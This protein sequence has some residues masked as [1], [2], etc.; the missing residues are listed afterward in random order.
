[1]KFLLVCT[2]ILGL[3]F[4]MAS[5]LP[6]LNDN[7]APLVGDGHHH[8]PVVRSVKLADDVQAPHKHDDVACCG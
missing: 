7:E 2:L 4:F 3:A 8:H 6:Q 1:M 5:A